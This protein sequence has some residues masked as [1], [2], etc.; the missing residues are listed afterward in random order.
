MIYK[1]LISFFRNMKKYPGLFIA[2]I[3]GLSVGILAVMFV[4]IYSVKEL[5]ADRF[6]RN[7]KSI[8]RITHTDTSSSMADSNT[9]YPMGKTID[10]Q[11][12]EIENFT[13]I[14]TNQQAYSVST[15]NIELKKQSITFVDKGF[16][17]MFSFSL[18]MGEPQ[19]LFENPKQMIISEEYAQK[20]FGKRNPLGETVRVKSP[21]TIENYTIVGVLENFPDNSTLTPHIIVDIKNQKYE[22]T[23]SWGLHSPQLFLQLVENTNVSKLEQKILDVVAI[24]KNKA[25]KRNYKTDYI[26]QP[27]SELYINSSNVADRMPK[28]DL[29]IVKIL[30]ICGIILLT[31]VS[32]NYLILNFGF[33]IKKSSQLNIQK[34]LGATKQIQIKKF[35]HNSIAMVIIAFLCSLALYPLFYNLISTSWGIRYQL[36]SPD[37]Y[38][39]WF[40]ILILMIAFGLFTGL[41]QYFITSSIIQSRKVNKKQGFIT[42][43][44]SFQLSIFIIAIISVAGIHKQ[45]SY[46]Q[47]S[48]KGFDLE[49]TYHLSFQS[50]EMLDQFKNEFESYPFIKAMSVGE[51][52]YQNEYR[53][54]SFKLENTNKTI[55]AQPLIGDYNFLRAYNIQLLEG[56]NLDKEKIQ[57]LGH[58]I[59]MGNGTI[60]DVLVNKTFVKKAGLENPIGTILNT[61]AHQIKIVGVFNDVKNLPF[62]YNSKPILLAYNLSG[63][64]SALNISVVNGQEKAFLEAATKFYE[65][66]DLS[67]YLEFL[68]WHYDFEN[69]YQK[70]SN[71]MSF[72][73]IITGIILFVLLIGIIGLSLHIAEI[74]TKEIGIRK[75]NGAKISE[76]LI[77]LNKDFVKWITLA[78]IVA[79]PIAI[80]AMNKWLENFAYKTSLS[81]WIFALAGLLALGI[82]L[83]T[84]S[85]Q[86]W[87]AATR[88]PVEALR[89]E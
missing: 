57:N 38:K 82:T 42:A 49:N 74:K 60:P 50:F 68:I 34:I 15:S 25:Y 35:V 13:R 11:C 56:Q 37:D 29:S 47:N 40:G 65:Q 85:L 55:D 41:L 52:L 86:S 63:A 39:M 46:M 77:L 45:L 19:P 26:L 64:I 12:P 44:V 76:V 4:Y 43:L 18:A 58:E 31:F 20:L 73:N 7:S 33:Y 88:N 21:E 32:L 78:F 61:P 36:F 2:N 22:N 89:Y 54:E 16:F 72:F 67:D 79:T 30:I 23:A 10:T 66:Q 6:H 62:Y 75:V 14:E 59:F 80:Y 8:Y 53:H 81:W 28:G 51:G 84:V 69:E 24:E 27:L 87:K 83:L 5:S 70:E 9:P 48:N 3:I 71:L 17:E 1:D